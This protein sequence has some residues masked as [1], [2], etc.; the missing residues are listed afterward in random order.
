MSSTP[1][2]FTRY[3]AEFHAPETQYVLAEEH[4]AEIERLDMQLA[5]CGAVALANTESSAAQARVMHPDYMSASCGDVMRAVD[6]EMALRTERNRL[7]RMA[8]TLT[9]ELADARHELAMERMRHNATRAALEDERRNAT[10]YPVEN[11]ANPLLTIES[12]GI[13]YVLEVFSDEDDGDWFEVKSATPTE[14]VPLC[15]LR[16]SAVPAAREVLRQW[17]EDHQRDMEESRGV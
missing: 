6:R 4:D 2:R 11:P 8:D 3:E 1:K 16:P 9:R 15:D 12:G 5:A 17:R 13:R 14:P 10:R 7:Q